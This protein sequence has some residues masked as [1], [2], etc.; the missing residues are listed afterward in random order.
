MRR[1]TC[2][3]KERVIKTYSF[4]RPDRFP[5]DFCA[6]ASMYK[7]LRERL[8]CRNDFELLDALHV[9]FRWAR[10]PYIG[11]E[12]V[13]RNGEPTDY[14]GVPRRG[15]GDFGNATAHPLSHLKSVE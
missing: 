13:T 14:F 4:E 12:L 8:H 11:P 7:A 6:C 2:T 1:E 5:V 9:D 3:A 15:V 10:A